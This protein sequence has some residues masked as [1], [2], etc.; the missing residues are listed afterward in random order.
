[1]LQVGRLRVW[2]FFVAGVVGRVG[3]LGRDGALRMGADWAMGLFCGGC[4]WERGRIERRACGLG[5]GRGC[6]LRGWGAVV[7]MRALR[8]WDLSPCGASA[9]KPHLS[10]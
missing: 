3:G 8:W 10:A 4:G 6:V 7:G 1:M 2:G 9:D 5:V